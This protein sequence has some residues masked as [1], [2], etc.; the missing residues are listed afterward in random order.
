M[1]SHLVGLLTHRIQRGVVLGDINQAVSRQEFAVVRFPMANNDGINEQDNDLVF[2]ARYSVSRVWFSVI[3]VWVFPT[4]VL[5]YLLYVDMLKGNY[6]HAFF[7]S[8]FLVLALV[9]ILDSTFFK[10]LR[11]YQ[12]RVVKVWHVFGNRTIYYRTAKVITPAWWLRWLSCVIR[13]TTED[14]KDLPLQLPVSFIA[15]LF[16]SYSRKVIGKILDYLTEDTEN[17][18][19]HFKKASLPKE[20]ICHCTF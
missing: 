5:C 2:L 13:E 7:V 14:G 8:V 16:P 15:C 11:F 20:V 6:V 18:S 10:E 3:V 4:W 19:R 12:N 17:T 9:A 1:V